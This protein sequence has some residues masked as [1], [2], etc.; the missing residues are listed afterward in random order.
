MNFVAN[1]Y[2]FAISARYIY[3]NNSV[4]AYIIFFDIDFTNLNKW[5]FLNINLKIFFFNELIK[6]DTINKRYSIFNIKIILIELALIDKWYFYYSK[7][8]FSKST[9]RNK[10][11]LNF[12]FNNLNK[13]YICY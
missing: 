2:R 10:L 13:E 11:I 8:I 7:A 6:K 9:I 5:D 3:R 1:Q 12:K 4:F